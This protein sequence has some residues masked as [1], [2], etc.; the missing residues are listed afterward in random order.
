[1]RGEKVHDGASSPEW[2]CPS[3]TGAGRKKRAHPACLGQSGKVAYGK[4]GVSGGG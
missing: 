3:G 2:L 4:G 1:M